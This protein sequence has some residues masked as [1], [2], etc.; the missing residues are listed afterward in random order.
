MDFTIDIGYEEEPPGINL[1]EGESG[2]PEIRRKKNAAKEKNMTPSNVDKFEGAFENIAGISGYVASGIYNGSGEI[3]ASRASG[4]FNIQEVGGLAIELYKSARSIAEKMGMGVCNFVEIHTDDY[5]F[6]HSCIV[7]G[8]GAM[9]VLLKTSGNI[10]LTRH[11]MR[12]EAKNLV[13]EFL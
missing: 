10:G 6:I 13:S 11:Q 8:K 2:K 1:G 4:E 7:P 12:K 3:L 5:I 9:G